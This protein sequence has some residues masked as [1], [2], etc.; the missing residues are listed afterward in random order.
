MLIKWK[1][2]FLHQ[3]SPLPSLPSS[4]SP[5][6]LLRLLLNQW[7]WT[8]IMNWYTIHMLYILNAW[9][10]YF[11]CSAIMRRP[12]YCPLFCE[13]FLLYEWF[14]PIFIQ[15][16]F[17]FLWLCGKRFRKF[18][19]RGVSIIVN[20][21]VMLS[22]HCWIKTVRTQQSEW[23]GLN[24]LWKSCYLSFFAILLKRFLCYWSFNTTFV[25]VMSASEH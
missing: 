9:S 8:W 23:N 7:C 2:S 11:P 5:F 19:S 15:W 18:F 4:P 14:E 12:P 17:F 6:L 3:I 1:R 24:R 16:N 10:N 22:Q 21:S 20:R 25:P 13:S